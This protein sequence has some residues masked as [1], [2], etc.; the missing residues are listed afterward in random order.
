MKTRAQMTDEILALRRALEIVRENR[1]AD[2]LCAQAEL[3]KVKAD[4]AAIRELMN[5][6]NLGGW[7]DALEP[8]KRA[9][10][11][12][13]ERDAAV[14]LVRKAFFAMQEPLSP[15][16]ATWMLDVRDECPDAARKEGE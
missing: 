13:A 8:M 12:E 1:D 3:A 11:A 6:Y 14:A 9:L 4:E 15:E 2:Q 7:T 5:V 10:K 16:L